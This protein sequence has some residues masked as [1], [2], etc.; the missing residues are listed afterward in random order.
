MLAL[1]RAI[2]ILSI[3]LLAPVAAQAAS[4]AQQVKA[5][6]ASYDAAFNS[7]R[8]NAVAALLH[9]ERRPPTHEPRRAQG[10]GRDRQ[11]RRRPVQGR[12]SQSQAQA[13]RSQRRW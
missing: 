3:A 4:L 1:S 8:P 13:D 9:G 12:Y 2:V 6:Y 10:P 7:G 5:A 11:V